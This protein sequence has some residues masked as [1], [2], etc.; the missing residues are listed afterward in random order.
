[1]TR[2]VRWYLV[3]SIIVVGLIALAGCSHYMLAEREPWRHDAEI[4]CLNSGAVKESP[5]RVR[6]ASISG[7]GACGM[8]YPLKVSAL[9]EPGPLGYTDEP[10]TPPGA[11]PDGAMPPRWPINQSG[12]IQSQ[13]STI[14]SNAL[15][16]LQAGAPPPPLPQPGAPP[17]NP[18]PYPQAQYGQPQYPQPQYGSPQPGPPMS[19]TPPGVPAPYGGDEADQPPTYTPRPLPAP[20]GSST[21]PPY[22]AP[23]PIGPPAAPLVTAAA[24]PVEVKPAATLACPIV[25][26]LDQWISGAVQPAAQHW[27]RQP[28]VEIKQISAYSCRGMNGDPNA[29]ISEHAFGN[30]LDIAEF[31]LA[32]GHRISVQYGWHGTPEEQGFLHDLQAAACDEFTTVLAPGANVYHYNHIHVDLMRHYGGKHICEPAAIPGDVVAERARAHYAA[33][34]GEPSIT[35]S[36]SAKI[37]RALGYSGDDDH[38]PE[39]VP[40][41]D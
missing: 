24:G 8:D 41:D 36:I 10:L 25:S 30:A 27:F 11:I 34:H 40:G 2:G 7:P 3:S 26:A 6:I 31:T 32:D 18:P 14:Q 20:I 37:H 12:T 1:M 15:P 22:G 19:L 28:V 16:P 17:Y 13:S 23:P 21:P 29:H 39:A 5:A 33:Q 9:G 38:L 4:A 35:G